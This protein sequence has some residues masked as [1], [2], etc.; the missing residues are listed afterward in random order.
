[1]S[2]N[3]ALCFFA[4][5]SS[6]FLLVGMLG[7]QPFAP[8]AT[9][10]ASQTEAEPVDA[11]QPQPSAAD[12]ARAEDLVET[13]YAAM[14]ASNQD[15]SKSVEAALAF[16]EALPIFEAAGKHE[17]MRE[18]NANIFWSRKRMNHDDLGR[19]LQNK[20]GAGNDA[21]AARIEAV[22]NRKV[23]LEE[24][25][26]WLQEADL[27][28]LEHP[29]RPLQIAIRYFEVAERFAGTPPSLSAQRKSLDY[30]AR[31]G[32]AAQQAKRETL[33]T[34][35][36]QVSAGR[37]PA[38]ESR[39]V[40]TAVRE[41]KKLYRE[42]YSDRSD[43]GKAALLKSF[44]EQAVKTKDDPVTAFALF[45]EAIALASQIRAIDD[46]LNVI[47]AQAKAFDIDAT[48]VKKDVL[49]RMR[50]SGPAKAVITLL[51]DPAEP[52]ANTVAGK[53]YAFDLRRWDVGFAML[54]M[55]Q[56]EQ[57]AKLA[58]MEIAKPQGAQQELELADAWFALGSSRN[59]DGIACWDRAM[60]WYEAVVPKLEGATKARATSRI[61]EMFG[62]V[63]PSKVD[64]DNL[65][66]EQWGKLKPVAQVVVA[67]NT[68]KTE[69]RVMLRP[70]QRARVVPHPAETWR[71]HSYFSNGPQEVTYKGKEYVSSTLYANADDDWAFPLGA[72]I[73][74]ID[75]GKK[76]RVGVIEGPGHIILRSSRPNYGN[77]GSIKVKI[78]LIDP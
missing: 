2:F 22:V 24:A 23:P 69:T 7:V 66:V 30:Q 43:G 57:L 31:A 16:A 29:D 42:G 15:P 34:R 77:R 41:L 12:L 67:C 51:D 50:T 68:P 33:F 1:M 18:L 11:P 9:A 35:P 17:R 14:Q 26:R 75:E 32:T 36:A 19:Y 48:Q 72:M 55:G 56:D 28:A 8:L 63:F 47:D 13:G 25:D 70:G 4:S 60:R 5:S 49:G 40:A 44:R 52:E 61:N 73:M 38:P 27:F 3:R 39:D 71:F 59:S 62:V 6:A 54:S 21:I 58:E 45:E 64:W 46:V 53:Y 78:L 10:E 20:P 65:T 76:S 37:R 74:Y